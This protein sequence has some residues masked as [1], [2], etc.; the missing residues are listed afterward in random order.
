MKNKIGLIF[1]KT[2]VDLDEKKITQKAAI[3]KSA[4]IAI[5]TATMILFHWCLLKN[6]NPI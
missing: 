6:V 3:K 2:I 5:S 4:Y 1:R